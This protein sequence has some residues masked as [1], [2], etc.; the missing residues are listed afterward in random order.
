M[1]LEAA[2]RAS[3]RRREGGRPCSLLDD[4]HAVPDTRIPV[5][6]E[7]DAGFLQPFPDQL[8]RQELIY[9]LAGNL[10]IRLRLV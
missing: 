3:V 9:L 7:L 8:P 2:A 1:I 4:R 5:I 10:Q 6:Q